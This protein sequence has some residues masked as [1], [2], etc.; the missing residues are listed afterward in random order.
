MFNHVML[1]HLTAC[2]LMTGVLWVIQLVHY[3]AFHYVDS[4]KFQDFINMHGRII[5]IFVMPVMLIELMT[6]IFL[7]ANALLVWPWQKNLCRKASVEIYF[8][9]IER[10]VIYQS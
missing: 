2:L 9:H 3:P 5:S 6:A 1:L 4:N 10:G 7:L 8:L